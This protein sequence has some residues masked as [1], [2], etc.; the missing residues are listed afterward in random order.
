MVHFALSVITYVIWRY[1][2]DPGQ[3]ISG[4]FQEEEGAVT[5]FITPHHCGQRDQVGLEGDTCIVIIIT[6][7]I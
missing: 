4:P 7:F 6:V 5:E 3:E 1:C 2:Q